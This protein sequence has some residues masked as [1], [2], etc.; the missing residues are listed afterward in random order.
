MK[1]RPLILL[2]L[3]LLAPWGSG[4]PARVKAASRS[5]MW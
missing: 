3:V 5:Y 4:V 1:A 2:V